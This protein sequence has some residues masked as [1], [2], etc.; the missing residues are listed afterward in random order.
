MMMEI[1]LIV[2][3]SNVKWSLKTNTEW[4]MVVKPPIVDVMFHQLNVLVLGL[5]KWSLNILQN[6]WVGIILMTKPQ[7]LLK[8]MV[9]NMNISMT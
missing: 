7:F 2:N 1:L 8:L 9:W 3:F 6:S 5:V 4:L